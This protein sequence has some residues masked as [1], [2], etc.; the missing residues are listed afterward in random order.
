MDF[1]LS[2]PTSRS[3]GKGEAILKLKNA[4]GFEKLVM[5]G[6][7]ATDLEACPPADAFICNFFVSNA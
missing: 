3:G 7:G 2:Q 6:D 1:D 5:I 4:H